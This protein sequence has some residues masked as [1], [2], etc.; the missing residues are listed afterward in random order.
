MGE[1]DLSIA[2]CLLS[3]LPH[4]KAF[5]LC[6]RLLP[7]YLVFPLC[8]RQQAHLLGYIKISLFFI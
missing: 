7:H 8:S 3:W 1:T 6:K 2:S 4:C 5:P